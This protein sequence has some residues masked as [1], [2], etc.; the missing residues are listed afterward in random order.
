[1]IA[2]TAHFA[3]RAQSSLAQYASRAARALRHF[4]QIWFWLRLMR[5]YVSTQRQLMSS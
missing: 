1:M 5:T 4:Q 3:M 2:C